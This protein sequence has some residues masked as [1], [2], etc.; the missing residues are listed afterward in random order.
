MNRF[1]IVFLVVLG[2]GVCGDGWAVSKAPR[3][4]GGFVLGKA[5]SDFADVVDMDTALPI[6]YQEYL[7]EVEIRDQP[8]FKSGLIAYGTCASPGRIVRIKLKYADS[9][10]KFYEAL[11][12][13]MISRYGEPDEWRGDPFHVVLAWKWAFVGPDGKRI[14]MILQHNTLD[15]EQKMGNSIKLTCSTLL[16]EEQA[17]FKK[18]FPDRHRHPGTAEGRG[19]G[20]GRASWDRFVPQ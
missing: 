8:G 5:I 1:L 17:C 4:V 16:E 6:R 11:L 2:I 14:S 13:R 3:E 7:T 18:R 20:L 9:S 19:K 10:K 12:N 15:M